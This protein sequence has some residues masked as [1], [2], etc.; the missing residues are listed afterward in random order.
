MTR[1]T[2][3]CATA[4]SCDA[5]TLFLFAVYLYCENSICKTRQAFSLNRDQ[6]FIPKFL[7][8]ITKW[9]LVW[10]R[11]SG[12]CFSGQVEQKQTHN[13]LSWLQECRKFR[14]SALFAFIK[15]TY[16]VCHFF[17]ARTFIRLQW[18][19]KNYI[20]WSTRRKLNHIQ[21]SLV[22]KPLHPWFQLEFEYQ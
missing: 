18:K 5:V 14:A 12:I 3:A 8:C 13:I 10:C 11:I 4:L 19:C 9:D 1:V 15:R 22:N 7:T 6:A 17:P 20:P 21:V 16:F 2:W